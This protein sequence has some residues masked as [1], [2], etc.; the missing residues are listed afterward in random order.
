MSLIIRNGDIFTSGAEA[1]VNPVNIQGVARG[2]LARIF[3]KRFPENFR[4]YVAAC[5]NGSL[6]M[7]SVLVTEIEGDFRHIVNMPT[8]VES[9]G[10]AQLA[11]IKSG[12]DALM[13]AVVEYGMDSVAIPALG[14]GIGGLDFD[15]VREVVE[16]T[17]RCVPEVVFILYR[18]YGRS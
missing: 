4:K 15:G 11:Y 14:A 6:V 8:V 9:G 5:E 16:N 7:G 1:V 12:M 13:D 10:K 2:G 3:R 17:V 18:P